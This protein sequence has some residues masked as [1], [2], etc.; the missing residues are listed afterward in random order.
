MITATC[1]GVL[2]T[3][4]TGIIVVEEEDEREVPLQGGTTDMT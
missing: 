3:I 1:G 4:S 2:V